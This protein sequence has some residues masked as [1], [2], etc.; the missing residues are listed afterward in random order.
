[1]A[2]F[3]LLHGAWHTSS[4]W[5]LVV[6]ELTR[7][8]HRAVA[9]NLP[10]RDDGGADPMQIS[11]QTHAECIK[12]ALHRLTR[13]N[14]VAHSLSGFWAS[15]AV[16]QYDGQLNWM[17][18]LCAYV[19]LNGKTPAEVARLDPEGE[20]HDAIVFD[21]EAGTSSLSPSSETKR[22]LY[23]DCDEL[24]AETAVAEL[25]S[26]PIRPAME[27]IAVSE[28]FHS[29]KKA[30]IECLHDR[31]ISIG[32]QRQMQRYTRFDRVETMDTGHSP[33]LSCPSELTRTLAILAES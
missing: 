15:Q 12:D 29:R 23:G 20:I 3:L 13:P 9:V 14:L 6:A 27:P 16:E 2:D 19:P 1:M 10:G 30:Y 5:D 31:V 7:L 22:L 18:F 11:V 33:F 17:V 32:Y 24:L 28:A 25:H 8:G 21:P 26:E 4:C